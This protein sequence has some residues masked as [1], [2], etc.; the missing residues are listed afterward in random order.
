MAYGATWPC[1][2]PACCP[3][4]CAQHYMGALVA[5]MAAGT[6]SSLIRVP[7]E[8]VKQRLQTKEYSGAI[9]AVRCCCPCCV[10]GGR[11]GEGSWAGCVVGAGP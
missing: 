1:V 10:K 6:A 4:A 8:V 5:G 9:N 2:L 3:R 11:Q 7:T